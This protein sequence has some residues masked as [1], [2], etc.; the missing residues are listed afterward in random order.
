VS[1]PFSHS[2]EF[3]RLVAGARD[4]RLARVALELAVDAYPGLDVEAYLERIKHL[5]ARVRERFAAGATLR[6]ILG[7]INWVLYVEEELRGNDEDYSDPRNSYLND[8]LDRRL[9][10]PISLS[11]VHWSV[12]EQLGVAIAGVNLPHHFMLRV[13]EAGQTRFVDPFHAGA[14]YSREKCEQVLTEI[15]GKPIALTESVA[16]PCSLA[17]VVSRMLRNLKAVYLNNEDLASLL[18][19]QRRLTALNPGSPD[20]LRDLAII[21]VQTEHHGEA[22]DRLEAY[23][24]QTPSPDDAPELRQLL[25]VVRRHVA[26]WN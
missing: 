1:D 9:G 10:I 6:E 20:E 14:V 4:V 7:Q 26:R 25:E 17:V 13:D 18:P 21:C 22:I 11:V 19:V 24:R 3:H 8:V 16:A 2:P 23:F 5:A 12:A 15:A